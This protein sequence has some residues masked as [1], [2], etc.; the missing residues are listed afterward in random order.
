MST[1]GDMTVEDR[2]AEEILEAIK[3]FDWTPGVDASSSI[4]ALAKVL[5]HI[6]ENYEPNEEMNQ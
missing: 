1:F 3:Y 6:S 4:C 2:L 5:L